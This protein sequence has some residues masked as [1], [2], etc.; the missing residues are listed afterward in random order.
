MNLKNISLIYLLVASVAFLAS[1]V[2]AQNFER[3][4]PIDPPQP[5]AEF[6]QL[7]QE[8]KPITGSDKILLKKLEA[9]IVL[10]HA[11]KVETGGA[12][13]D[14]TG[15]VRNF[16]N[17]KSLVFSSRFE[18]IVSQYLDQPVSLRSLNQLS[19]DIILLYRRCG[20]PVIDVIIPEQKI[21]QGTVQI[22]VIETRVGRVIVQDGCFFDGCEISK[23]IHCTRRGGILL[24]SRIENDLFWLN[25]NSFRQVGVDLKPGSCEGT[26]DVIFT[27]KD[28]FPARGY[29]GYDDTG[30]QSLGLSRVYTGFILGNIF[31]ADDT[32]SY[33]YTS[34][35]D[36]RKLHAHAATYTN[37]INRDYAF[38]TYGSWAA[39][40][41]TIAGGFL[42]GGESWQSGFGITRTLEKSRFVDESISFGFDFKATNNNLEFGGINVQNSDAELAQLRLGYQI[43]EQDQCDQYSRFSANAY[44]SPGRGFSSQNTTAAFSS[45]RANTTPQYMYG[46]I[47]YERA[48][49]VGCNWQL[50]FRGAAQV[51]SD[52]LL[53]SEMLGFG[54]YDTVRGY[55][56]R[57]VNGDHGWLASF[58]FGPRP[59]PLCIRGEK[60]RLRMYTFLDSGQALL[61]DPLPGENTEQTMVSAGVGMRMA[62]AQNISFRMDYGHGFDSVPFYSTSDRLHLGLVWQFGQLP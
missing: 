6:P 54:G 49:N 3:Y 23:W 60:G 18:N 48:K 62:V 39:S 35:S 57:S 50:A 45:I 24:E 12:A 30:V 16:S 29:V 38:Q 40:N 33:Q 9:L 20:Q 61:N 55:D 5:Q 43:N 51:T 58:E 42:Q 19:R 11:S 8:L 17:R 1:P 53:F 36:F 10:D 32:A 22:V 2:Q 47:N 27:T 28:V 13:P 59:I 37:P 4:R 46:R 7:E 21:S 44:F 26:T 52:R 25:Q 34:D 14:A 15:I 41:P 56:Q 31:N